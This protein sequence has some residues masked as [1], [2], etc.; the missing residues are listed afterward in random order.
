LT[1]VVSQ[2]SAAYLH[3]K[4]KLF[5][6]YCYD[7]ENSDVASCR[8]IIDSI[9]DSEDRA[10]QLNVELWRIKVTRDEGHFEKAE[11]LLKEFLARIHPHRDWYAYFSAHI[12]LGGLWAAQNRK[13]EAQGLLEEMRKTVEKSPFR[14]LKTQ[15]AVLEKKLTVKAPIPE[16]LCEQGIRSWKLSFQTKSV[17]LKHQ[18]SAARLFELFTKKSWVEKAQMAK[19]LLRKDYCPSEDDSKIHLQVHHLRK[20]LLEL[21]CGLDPICFEEGG[22][23]LIP[24]LKMLEGET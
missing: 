7:Y 23:R 12:L 3:T 16:L 9:P 2:A 19:K 6:A 1:Q 4:A 17:E 10:T 18:T 20:L 5:L 13:E 8:R 21:E 11:N 15:L 22:Y 14:T 24:S